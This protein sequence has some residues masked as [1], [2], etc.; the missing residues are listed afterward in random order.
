MGA[1]VYVSSL[2]DAVNACLAAARGADPAATPL[3]RL[4]VVA[5]SAPA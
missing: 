1:D 3:P 2:R 5:G 4:Q